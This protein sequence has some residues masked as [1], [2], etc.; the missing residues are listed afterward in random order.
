MKK[1]AIIDLGSNSIRMSI[2]D[3]SSPHQKPLSWR[4]VI[5][6]SEGLGLGNTLKKEAMKRAVESFLE[7]K[8]I[9]LQHGA[10]KIISVATAAV[11]KAHNKD[12]FL[13]LIEAE[14]GI[15]IQ[16]IDGKTE[17]LLDGLA[18]SKEQSLSKGIIADIGG[19]STELI[20]ILDGKSFVT[21][22]PLGS[23][24]ICERFFKDGETPASIQDALNFC[25]NELSNICWLDG[26][27]ESTLV[28]IG[29]TL[30]SVARICASPTPQRLSGAPAFA[31]SKLHK[32]IRLIE[33]SSPEERRLIPEIGADRSDIIMGGAVILKAIL[34]TLSPKSIMVSD[35]GVR[36]GVFFD[37]IENHGI[38]S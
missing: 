14:T 16:V 23:R 31:P 18:I 4:K 25:K 28:G 38:L 9:A 27:K 24:G 29:G 20:G 35:S 36:E 32:V 11:R 5:R 17:A 13:N 19:G 8:N 33:T 3:S 37:L 1:L 26:F 2:F 7:Y 12:E 22:L 6:L 30:H 21:S 10:D 34:D 15:K